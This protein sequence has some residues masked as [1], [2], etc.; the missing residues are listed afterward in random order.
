MLDIRAGGIGKSAKALALVVRQTT[1]SKAGQLAGELAVPDALLPEALLAEVRAFLAECEPEAPAGWVDTLARPGREPSRVLLVGVGAGDD[2][3]WRTAGA[4]LTRA[5]S[6]QAA[7]T[8]V[9]PDDV[10][11]RAV[12]AL[13]EGA[14][15]ASYR[16]QLPGP[17]SKGAAA[18]LLRRM[19]VRNR[20]RS[21]RAPTT[22]SV[23]PEQT[24]ATAKGSLSWP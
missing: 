6:K 3:A 13:A 18:S 8:V 1:N 2:D 21:I 7:L 5:A 4:Q 12:A 15:L 19:T 20:K 10:S 16:Y 11:E 17:A 14:W 9:L 22:A 23:S 24:T